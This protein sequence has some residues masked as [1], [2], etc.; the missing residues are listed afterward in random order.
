[1][2]YYYVWSENDGAYLGLGRSSS[3]EKGEKIILS[4]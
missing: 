4:I 1:M 2:L 3:A